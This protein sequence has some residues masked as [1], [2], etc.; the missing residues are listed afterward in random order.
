[1]L[2]R[3]RSAGLDAGQSALLRLLSRLS[4][5][6]YGFTTITPNSHRRVVDR[7]EGPGEDLRDLLGWSLP[8]LADRLDAEVLAR[9]RE[10][11]ALEEADGLVRSALRVST[12]ENGLFLHSA[13]PT[14]ARDSVFLGPDSYRFVRLLRK[15][16]PDR[17]PRRIVD[18]GAGAGV[19]G[20]VAA[21]F[22]PGAA[23]ELTDINP[24]ALRLAAVNA[25]AHGVEP[26]LHQTRGLDGVQPGFDLAIANPPFMAGTS[27]RTYSAGGG[28]CGEQ[29][30][31]DWACAALAG[32]APGGRLILYTGS[33]IARGGHDR[34]RASIAE[35]AAAAGA[36]MAY[37]EIDPD[38]FGCALS[39]E[40]YREI[41]RIAA[42]G[43]VLT[44][45]G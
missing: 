21:G 6:G 11:G 12:V 9:L 42:V 2:D 24:E 29:L 20:I 43:V 44:R 40:A 28:S 18:I 27:A 25:A 32:L 41:E 36:E 5:V 15:A 39:G 4:A 33:A 13:W 8:C 26:V 14:R 34:L 16:F 7:R 10:A 38:I 23:V 1:M 22:A 45:C 19:G 37:E 31:L 30:S 3:T 35:I 17:P